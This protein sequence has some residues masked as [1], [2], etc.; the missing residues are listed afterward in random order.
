MG[1]SG[2]RALEIVEVGPRD[3]FQGIGP[4]I[5]TDTK[6]RLLE[7]LVAAGLRRIEIGSFVSASA[8]ECDA[9]A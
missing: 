6:V 8:V 4:F 7:R 5:P 2:E 9:S 1:V 3:G